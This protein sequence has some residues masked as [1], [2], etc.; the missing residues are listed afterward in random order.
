M[1][2]EIFVVYSPAPRQVD[3]RAVQLPAPCTVAQVLERSGMLQ[4]YQELAKHA[5]VVGIW[6]RRC[7]M[8]QEVVNQDRVEVYRKLLVDPK[9]ARRERFKTQGIKRAGLFAKLRSGAKA[10][11]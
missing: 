11:Y 7:T 10:G 3:Q 2:I 4:D 9:V 5:L 6:G 8:N 1:A